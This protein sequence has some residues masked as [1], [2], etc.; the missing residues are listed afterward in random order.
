M[1]KKKD[2]P[3]VI[4]KSLETFVH[5]KGEMFEIIDPKENLLKAIDKDI[6]SSFHFTI[7]KYQS[8]NGKFEFLMKR[9]PKNEN[10]TNEIRTWVDINHLSRQFDGWIKLLTSYENVNSF[11]DDPIIN[12]YK[13]EFFNEFEIIDEGADIYPLNIK[14]ILVLDKHLEEI[15]NK[16]GMY[17]DPK[18]SAALQEI[19][20]QVTEL[21]ENLTN[22]SKKWVVKKLSTIWAKIAKQGTKFIKNIL[23]ESNKQIVVQSV[24]GVI[25]F[26]KENGP[27]LIN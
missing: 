9:S 21:R 19:K 11:F 14:Q 6:D 24:K 23:L 1:R 27:E 10:D 15:E 3:I 5:M 25:E 4:L 22:K 26:V 2:L 20:G 12:S 16:L 18:N 8:N 17:I 13:E 7:E